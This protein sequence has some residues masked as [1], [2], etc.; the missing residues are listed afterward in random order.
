MVIADPATHVTQVISMHGGLIGGGPSI[1][2]AADGLGIVGSMNGAF[3]VVPIDGERAH[4]GVGDVYD[5]RGFSARASPGCAS[6]PRTLAALTRPM[7]VSKSSRATGPPGPS[8]QQGA[9]RA[10]AAGFGSEPDGIG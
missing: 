6:A 9:D 10:L 1:V 4:P 5:P 7:V 2:W 8:R 3:Q